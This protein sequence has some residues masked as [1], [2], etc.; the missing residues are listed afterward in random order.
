MIITQYDNGVFFEFDLEDKKKNDI[1]LTNT[2]LLG[3]IVKPSGEKINNVEIQVLDYEK[4]IL[5]VCLEGD[6]TNEDGL[7]KLYIE[8][9]YETSNI[10]IDTMATYYVLPKNGGV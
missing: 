9:F 10:T 2:K 1:N 5:S 7:C 8:I 4:G 3:T 6:M